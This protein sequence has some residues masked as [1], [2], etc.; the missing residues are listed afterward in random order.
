MTFLVETSKGDRKNM[1][2][3]IVWWGVLCLSITFCWLTVLFR[4][5]IFLLTVLCLVV[6]T[7]A[8]MT[9]WN[10][11]LLFCICLF[12]L[13]PLS[14][15]SCIVM[16]CGFCMDTFK[17][18]MSTLQIDPLIIMRCPSMYLAIFFA[19]KSTLLHINNPILTFF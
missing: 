15:A 16:F 5:C 1:Y 3:S 10:L 13:S 14:G 19:L 2:C 12:L 7:V 6:T 18:I 9:I 11:H 8:Y 17:I 4:S